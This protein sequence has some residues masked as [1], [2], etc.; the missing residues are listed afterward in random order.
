MKNILII[1]SLLI[2]VVLIGWWFLSQTNQPDS[3]GSGSAAEVTAQ[4]TLQV[5]PQTATETVV[6]QNATLS[7]PG[8]LVLREEIDGRAAQVVEISPYLA[9]GTYTDLTIPVGE[10]YTG[11]AQLMVVVYSD[12]ENDTVL[13]DL[14]QPFVDSTGVTVASY[15]ATGLAVPASIFTS[16]PAVQPM[17]KGGMNMNMQTVRYTDT[18]FEPAVLEV[19]V[20]T[21][22][23]FV[24]DSAMQMWVASNPHPAH[25]ILPTFDQFKANDSF[26]YT[27]TEVGEWQY[28]D[29]LNPT[30]GGT[31]IVTAPKVSASTPTPNAAGYIKTNS[32]DFELLVNDPAVTTVNV[33]IPY[34]GEIAGTE[35]S[36]PYNDTQALLAALPAD[37]TA[38]VALYCR[39]GSMSAVA[40]AA[41]AEAG[42]TTIYDLTG[43]MN[44]YSD[45]GREVIVNN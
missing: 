18:G 43:G 17:N 5:S 9:A 7:E 21:M 29:H 10:F 37:K 14:D 1:I 20:G 42:Y 35:A 19:E 23:N 12:A 11:E 2:V 31:I 36:V 24:N 25:T 33:H 41:V 15:V 44:A 34:N 22:V 16:A 28:H 30:A 45:S 4:T 26:T 8:F 6:I 27:F 13:N 39:S 3:I 32:A 38:P 40:A